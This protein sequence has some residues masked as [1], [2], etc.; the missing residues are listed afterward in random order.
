MNFGLRQMM[1]PGRRISLGQ[2]LKGLDRP[3]K[4]A[5]VACEA[6]GLLE[7]A[8]VGADAGLYDRRSPDVL[9]AALRRR[10]AEGREFAERYGI[11][12]GRR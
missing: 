3:A 8:D 7:G 5:V 9:T 6:A 1:A 11:G 10:A 12:R 4:E 2:R